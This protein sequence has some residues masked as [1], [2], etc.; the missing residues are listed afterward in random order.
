MSVTPSLKSNA[1][2]IPAM[3]ATLRV[4]LLLL[5]VVLLR[6][7]PAQ[8]QTTSTWSGGGGEWAPCPPTGNALWNTC[9]TAYPDGNYN[10]VIQGG[11]VTLSG[12]DG[13]TIVNLTLTSGS[14][15]DIVGG[16]VFL[17]GNSLINNGTITITS[18]NGLALIGQGMTVTLSGTGTVNLNSSNSV[19]DGTSGSNPTLV[20]QQTI[21]GQG[22]LGKEGFSITNQGTINAMGGTLT[23]QPSSAGITN[24][25]LMEASSGGTLLIVYG[26]LGPFNNTGGTI[27]AL[28][29]GIVQLQGEIYTGGT[30]TTNGTGVIQVSGGTV[31]NAL[32]NS[33]S[34]QVSSNTG[35]LQNTV[36]NSGTIQLQSGTLTMTGAVTLKGSGSL[37]M[38]G[39]SILGQSGGGGSLI[40]QQLI[41]GAGTIN[42]LPLTNQGTVEADNTSAPLYLSGDTTANTATNTATL[43]AS[44]GATLVIS[45]GQTVNNTGGVIEALAGSTVLLEGTVNGGTLKTS[46]T[47]VI[48]SQDGTLDGTVNTPT[49]TGTFKVPTSYDLT[50]EGTINN[51]GTIALGTNACIVLNQPTTLTG[52]GKITMASNSC[53]YGS[54]NSLTNQSTIQGIGTIGDSN[55]MPITNDG[56]ILA[57]G[58]TPLNIVPNSTGFTN[59]GKLMANKGSMLIINSSEG[60]FTNLSGG[61]L[62]GGTY[63]VTGTLELGSAITTNAASIT[64]TGASA[65]IL[66]TSTS[67]NA[68]AALAANTSKGVLSLQ[69]G[70][71]LAT[72]ANFSNAGKTTVG[73]S[74]SFTVGGTYTQTAG[75]TTVDG[76]LTA[77]TGLSLEKGTLLGQGK[78]AAAVTSSSTVTVG[79]STSKAGLLTVSGAYTQKPAGVL[80]VAIGGTTVGS[81]YS[82]LA[83]SNGVSL[84]GTL[85]IKL[86]NGF[87][88]TIGE[89]F[90]I[91]TGSAVSGTFSKVNGTSINSSEHFDVS[92]TATA[93]TLTVVSGT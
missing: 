54:G 55:P 40:N 76:T 30:L 15:L 92:Y 33:G 25:S 13:D 29:G 59:N 16:Y 5:I 9:P 32:T 35:V 11:P 81:Q 6:N 63:N 36:T 41:H 12:T 31:L 1:G 66:N 53:I 7:A 60:P 34:L 17:T 49:N 52:S 69:G 39:S 87:V 79:D 50:M 19:F 3:L 28:D 57:N 4:V 38:S 48:E 73:A 70:Q 43:E 68:L 77:P 21:M 75:Q 80:D 8:A 14:S 71:A 67:T 89:T 24:T 84:N 20:N 47:G 74:S 72:S 23:V 64:L 26:F 91:L 51:T 85:T 44:G 88:P 82:Q 90:T 56:T 27:K 78:L 58:A 61:T 93:V 37:I 62:T 65:E 46:G 2:L 42:Q 10:A 45:G 22:S 86:I 83:V 18:G